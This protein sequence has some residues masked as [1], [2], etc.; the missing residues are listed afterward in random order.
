LASTTG[1]SAE[2]RKLD[3]GDE[4]RERPQWIA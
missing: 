1:G 4:L 2:I 3:P